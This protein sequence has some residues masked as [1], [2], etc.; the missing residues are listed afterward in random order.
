MSP[1]HTIR[2]QDV[3]VSLLELRVRI[4]GRPV[5]FTLIELRLLLIFLQDPYKVI[6]VE[7]LAARADLAS[8]SSVQVTIHR[9]RALLSQR[10]IFT[11]GHGQGYSFAERGRLKTTKEAVT[12]ETGR[13]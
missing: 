6:P 4:A 9:M 2:F 7:E 3:S 1:D 10:Y 8:S 12:T 11:R 5:H 13:R